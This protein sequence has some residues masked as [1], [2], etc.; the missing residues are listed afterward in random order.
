[1]VTSV[2]TAS[3]NYAL[4][5]A[6]KRRNG[7]YIPGDVLLEVTHRCNL[8][9]IHCYLGPQHIHGELST[10]EVEGI[11]DQL[12]EAG[13]LT[14][15]FSGGEA[16]CRPDIFEIM[17]YAKE[18]GFFFGLKTN[19]TL[20]TEP[21][22]D[23]LKELDI[24]GVHV[25]LYGAT[26]TT[27]EYV[28]G[29]VGSFNKTMHALKLLRERKFRVGI[30]TPMMKC[31]VK[32]H[33]DIENIAIQLGANYSPDPIVFSKL[34]QPGSA[35]LV[36]MDDEQLKMLINERNWVPDDTDV[37]H[38]LERHLICGA[39]RT[40]CAI[41]PQGEVFPCATWRLPL[42]D[43]KRQTF[44]DIWHGETAERIRLITVSDLSVCASC[45]LVGYCARCPGMINI[46]KGN[47]GISGPS[48]ENCRL[49]RAI[50]GVKDN[51]KEALC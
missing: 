50:K 25:S 13:C 8:K 46:E 3:R 22:A 37:M 27:H 28:T 51:G 43:L 42:G 9:C 11:L 34:G 41:S 2:G 20:I 5:Q 16:L 48:S 38:E 18:R 10:A 47:S 26:A 7:E 40:R 4:R 35:D 19:G 32:E 44:R 39:G 1:M 30:K 14:I 36:R 15:T 21:V 24:T 17:N 12:F 33:K 23:R 31:N 6:R 29:V 45:A 49:A